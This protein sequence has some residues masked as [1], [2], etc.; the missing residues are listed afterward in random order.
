VFLTC[1]KIVGVK[2][3]TTALN[4]SIMLQLCPRKPGHWVCKPA[5]LVPIPSQDKFIG[6]RQQGN[7]AQKWVDDRCRSLIK[8]RTI[9]PKLDWIDPVKS[10][11]STSAIQYWSATKSDVRWPTIRKYTDYGC[12]CMGV[13]W[14]VRPPMPRRPSP[15]QITHSINSSHLS[16]I[17]AL[18]TIVVTEVAVTPRNC[19][20]KV[21]V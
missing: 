2:F 3:E 6:L 12:R 4:V 19:S 8:G 16:W 13:C 15:T 17:V 14:M 10:A 20:T 11:A 18:G 5:Y 7:P 1:S 9:Q 21:A